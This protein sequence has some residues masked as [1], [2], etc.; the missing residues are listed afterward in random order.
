MERSNYLK[1][2]QKVAICKKGLQGKIEN[3]PDELIVEYNNIQYYPCKYIMDFDSMGN[4]INKAILH[5]L[6][7]NSIIECELVK[8]KGNINYG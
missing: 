2:C 5:D 7:A 6:K 1:L 4:P 8:V 3:I